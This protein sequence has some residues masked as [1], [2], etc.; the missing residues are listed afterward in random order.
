MCQKC[1]GKSGLWEILFNKKKY[2]ENMTKIVGA[3]W[4]LPAANPAH[5]Q[6]NWAG[7]AVLFRRQLTSDSH[8]I[9]SYFQHNTFLIK[10]NIP[11]NTFDTYFFSHRW[12]VINLLF[13]F[14]I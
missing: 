7:L 11:Q 9:F 10:K 14:E 8:Y 3:V 13:T 2:A 6:P 4:E 5:F 12:C 1:Y